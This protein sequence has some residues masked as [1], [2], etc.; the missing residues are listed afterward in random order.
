MKLAMA[1]CKIVHFW[2]VPACSSYK[3][4]LIEDV[5]KKYMFPWC[6]P[7]MFL[8]WNFH[9]HSLIEE[10]SIL[11]TRIFRWKP[12]G[13]VVIS[14]VCAG[15]GPCSRWSPWHSTQA[16]GGTA[17]MAPGGWETSTGLLRFIM[18]TIGFIY[19]CMILYV[20]ICSNI[21]TKQPF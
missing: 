20:F 9:V 6:F 8:H 11:F 18:D 7:M 5:S 1:C 15:L 10:C 16:R 2:I 14:H 19:T 12:P 21:N 13:S 4:P 17:G 3:P